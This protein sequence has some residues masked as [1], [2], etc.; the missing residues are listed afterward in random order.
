[1]ATRATYGTFWSKAWCTLSSLCLS[2]TRSHLHLSL[3]TFFAHVPWLGI[4]VGYIPGAATALNAL[5][6]KG[7]EFAQARVNRGSTIPDLFHYLVCIY[8]PI[9]LSSLLTVPEQ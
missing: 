3:A 4:Y 6:A 8:G 5:L 7:R 9:S 2:S 1:M